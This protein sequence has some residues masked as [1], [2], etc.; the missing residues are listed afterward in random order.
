MGVDISASLRTPPHDC[1]HLYF[2]FK[3]FRSAVK[4]DALFDCY[5]QIDDAEAQKTGLFDTHK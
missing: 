2:Q 4:K 3:K 5:M 1:R